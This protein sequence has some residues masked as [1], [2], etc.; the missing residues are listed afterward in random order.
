MA[1]TTSETPSSDPTR[2]KP[3]WPPGIPFIVGNEAAERFSFFGMKTILDIYLSELFVMFRDL[4]TDDPERVAAG[5]R[6]THDVHLF[7]AG[8][9]AFP[10]L[11]ALIADRLFGKYNVIMYLSLVYCAGHAVLAIASPLHNV[12]LFYVGLALIAIGSGGIKPCVSANVGDQFGPGNQQLVTKVYQIFYFAINFGSFF[13]T[14]LT[15]VLYRQFGPDVAFGVPGILMFIATVV[16]WMGRKKFVHVPARPGGK[17]GALDAFASTI[18]ATPLLAFL[19]G[20]AIGVGWL[21][22]FVVFVVC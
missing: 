8:V 6:A 17:L 15:P 14:L 1:T 16:F 21:E 4:P 13:S 22:W 20:E 3:K 5:L 2:S 11:G 18:L 10:M 7:V 9:Y 12:E 19:F